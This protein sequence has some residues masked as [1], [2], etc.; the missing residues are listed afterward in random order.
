MLKRI[1][2]ADALLIFRKLEDEAAS[3]LCVGT[4]WGWRVSVRGKVSVRDQMREV[5]LTLDN[6]IGD[7]ALRVDNVDTVFWYSEPG[8]MPLP[9]RD[10]VPEEARDCALVSVLLPLRVRPDELSVGVQGR[11]FR[12]K[13]LFLEI[14]DAYRPTDQ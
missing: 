4:L 6:G 1:S 3:V 11:P 5:T 2:Q 14:R 7:L 9:E 8:K 10:A 12:E 13:L